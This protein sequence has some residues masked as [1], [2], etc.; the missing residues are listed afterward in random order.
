MKGLTNIIGS[1]G[2]KP[3]NSQIIQ[4]YALNSEISANNFVVRKDNSLYDRY[5][6][7]G[8]VCMVNGNLG[9]CNVVVQGSNAMYGACAF[10]YDEG[11]NPNVTTGNIVAT[12]VYSNT[13]FIGFIKLSD[14]E[15]VAVYNSGDST[16]YTCKIT[17]ADNLQITVEKAVSSS[18][19]ANVGYTL[20]SNGDLIALNSED[21]Y[22]AQGAQYSKMLRLY[23]YSASGYVSKAVLNLGKASIVPYVKIIPIGN[24]SKVIL[25]S[26]SSNNLNVA[27]YDVAD[28]AI[29]LVKTTYADTA[30]MSDA[31]ASV[32]S[33]DG[34]YYF[35]G[36]EIGYSSS[37]KIYTA[38]V[39]LFEINEDFSISTDSILYSFDSGSLLTINDIIH[40]RGDDLVV[41]LYESSNS[42]I[43]VIHNIL[44]SPNTERLFVYDS[45]LRILTQVE[46]DPIIWTST[47]KEI[48]FVESYK[49]LGKTY[50]KA[51]SEI[52]TGL[53]TTKLKT[54][55]LGEIAIPTIETQTLSLSGIPVDTINAIKNTAVDE[56]KEEV[57]NGLNN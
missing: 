39:R 15:V 20:R 1:G 35:G 54:D 19:S 47:N 49:R 27:V 56:I 57:T 55:Q 21:V 38:K 29:S 34:N 42:S 13:T 2:S 18:F 10:T 9:I 22:T 37:S 7:G 3:Y 4:G 23:K 12:T 45:N 6:F 41:C 50:S 48:T 11:G 33:I 17:L 25:Y 24:T 26:P 8:N 53:T 44:N 5:T 31:Y 14:N 51:E 28:S 36:T 40:Q 52:V 43:Y 16:L 46:Q 32:L 30:S